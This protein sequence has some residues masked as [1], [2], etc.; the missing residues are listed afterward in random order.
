MLSFYSSGFL[1]DLECK[2]SD[3]NKSSI[4]PTIENISAP[5]ESSK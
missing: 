2:A 1:G 3:R 5:M 4:I